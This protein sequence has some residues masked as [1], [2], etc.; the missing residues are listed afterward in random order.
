MRKNG[1]RTYRDDGNRTCSVYKREKQGNQRFPGKPRKLHYKRRGW[2]V[3]KA[4]KKERNT[5]KKKFSRKN[6]QKICV[7]RKILREKQKSRKFVKKYILK[8]WSIEVEITI[9]FSNS[10]KFKKALEIL[11]ISEAKG[12]QMGKEIGNLFFL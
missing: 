6:Y 8:N 7:E 2:G 10:I 12:I 5:R 4:G 11:S 1:N 9:Y 3:K